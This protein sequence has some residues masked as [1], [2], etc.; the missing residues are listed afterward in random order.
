ADFEDAQQMAELGTIAGE[1]GIKISDIWATGDGLNSESFKLDAMNSGG[2]FILASDHEVTAAIVDIIEQCGG[3]GIPVDNDGDGFPTG[4]D[5]DD[6]EPNAFPGNPEIEDGIDNDC[7][8][9]IDDGLSVDTDNDGILDDADNCP[10][11]ENPNQADFDGDGVGDACEDDSG[12]LNQILEQIQNIL[13]Q[14]LGLDNRV[15][16]LEDRVEQLESTVEELQSSHP[17]PDSNSG[18]GVG[19]PASGKP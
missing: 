10:F 4:L 14:L 16:D 11:T 19:V 9:L 6:S 1:Q 3:P 13:A 8:G 15:S 18:N 7:N 12:L 2:L 17:W 5:C